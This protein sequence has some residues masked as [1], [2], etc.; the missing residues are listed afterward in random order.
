VSARHH[1]LP[2]GKLKLEVPGLC[3]NNFFPYREDNRQ[4][5]IQELISQG[6]IPHEHELQKHPEKS[7]EGRSCEDLFNDPFYKNIHLYPT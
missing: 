6:K 5:E 4:A 3:L 7:L 2:R 1:T